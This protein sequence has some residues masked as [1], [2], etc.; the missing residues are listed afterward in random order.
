MPL[1]TRITDVRHNAGSG[2]FEANVTLIEG[3][4]SYTYS[5]EVTAPISA[6][7]DQVKAALDAKAKA[8][9][10]PSRC[11][12]TRRRVDKAIP[13][14]TSDVA[15]HILFSQPNYLEQILAGRVA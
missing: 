5:C 14:R 6:E 13:N 10:C 3:T 12:L 8:Q 1:K 11:A 15:S 9:H 7:V 2:R 4:E